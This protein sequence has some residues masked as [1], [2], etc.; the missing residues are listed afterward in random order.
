M[1]NIY[2]L[3]TFLYYNMQELDIEEQ[4]LRQGQRTSIVEVEKIIDN[5]YKRIGINFKFNEI[6]KDGTFNIIKTT[7]P[8]KANIHEL[9]HG[10]NNYYIITEYFEDSKTKEK[11]ILYEG[12]HKP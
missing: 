1:Q 10:N 7:Y 9:T 5:F 4:N 11:I 2:N 3:I 8:K 6:I 12:I